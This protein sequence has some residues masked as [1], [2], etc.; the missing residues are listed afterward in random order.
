MEF[1]EF[2]EYAR[3]D[4]LRLVLLNV[5]DRQLAEDLV[6]EASPGRGCRGGRCAPIGRPVPGWCARR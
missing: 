6:A 5:G 1:A 3:D 4:C 2:Y